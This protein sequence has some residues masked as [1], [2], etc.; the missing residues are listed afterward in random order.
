MIAPPR[1]LAPVS[2][3]G[4]A[5]LALGAVLGSP[6]A[7]AVRVCQGQVIGGPV[8]GITEAVARRGALEAWLVKAKAF[9]VEFASWRVA[10]A[11][12]VVCRPGQ[13]SGVKCVAIGAPC[14]IYQKA[15]PK[16]LLPGAKPAIEADAGRNA[17]T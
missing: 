10:A 5:A 7:A 3:A 17:K 16:P 15:P 11:K 13:P 14:R 9:G 8:S 12:S 1:P 4:L 6:A 2:A